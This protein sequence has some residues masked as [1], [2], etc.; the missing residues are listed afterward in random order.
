MKD[1]I[2]FYINLI[3]DLIEGKISPSSFERIFPYVF[4]RDDNLNKDEYTILNKLYYVVEDYVSNPEIRDE[5]DLNDEDLFREAIETL[6][7]LKNRI[8]W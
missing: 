1:N 3:N 6:H 5:N 2:A 7:R 4:N 8:Q